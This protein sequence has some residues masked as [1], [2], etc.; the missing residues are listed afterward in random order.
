MLVI[1]LPL[2]HAVSCLD[3][4]VVGD[5]AID[6]RMTTAKNGQKVWFRQAWL[7]GTQEKNELVFKMMQ[8]RQNMTVAP[9]VECVYQ[10]PEKNQVEALLSNMMNQLTKVTTPN[11]FNLR[12]NSTRT[13]F[14]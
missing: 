3:V 5:V 4:E 1:L 14:N 12:I 11:T 9:E 7:D 10:Y 6:L 13:K 2:V 8:V